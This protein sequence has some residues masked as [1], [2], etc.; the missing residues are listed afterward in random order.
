MYAS[1]GHFIVELEGPIAICR[2]WSRPDVDREEGARFDLA[3]VEAFKRLV[4]E[5]AATVASSVLDM[6]RAPASWGPVTQSCLERMVAMFETAGRRV[7][8]VVSADP[9]QRLQMEHIVHCYAPTQGRLFD[10]LDVAKAW[11][12][13]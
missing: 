12:L 8:V 10:D 6:T 4:A 9:S 3:E 2:M 5:P 7:A 1:G 13:Q 11:L